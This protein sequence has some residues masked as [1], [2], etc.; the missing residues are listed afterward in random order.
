MG[1]LNGLKQRK[2]EK[3]FAADTQQFTAASQAWEQEESLLNE[4]IQHV[5]LCIA[6]KLSEVFTD[7][8]DYGFML[9][10][11]E[12]GVA[13]I[14]N[15]GYIELVKAPSQYSAGY[16]GVSF[17][18][19]AGIRVNTGRIQGKRIPGAESIAMTDTGN[20]LVTN[21]RVMFQGSKRTQEWKFEK[22]MAMSH[23]PGGIT[24]FA[25][26][27]RGKPSGLGYGDAVASQVQFRF[28]L[29]SALA[30]NTLPRFRAELQVEK[31][32]HLAEKPVPPVPPLPAG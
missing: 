32:K 19:F 7:T 15:C 25:M 11:S 3:K 30:L 4:M 10:G 28:E 22:M 6:G 20:A 24:T 27:T 29:A 31:D 5:D 8:G 12:F 13:F 17:P 14:Q 1:F 2:S 9:K 18:L 23:L 21:T 26:T 16:G